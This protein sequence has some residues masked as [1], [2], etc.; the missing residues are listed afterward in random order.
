MMTL[1]VL[2]TF[3]QGWNHPELGIIS[4]Y[5]FIPIRRNTTNHSNRK[6]DIQQACQQMKRWHTLGY[7]HLK[8]GAR[9]IC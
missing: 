6:M 4:P 5:E 2:S 1:S 3:N 8:I 7:S 9:F